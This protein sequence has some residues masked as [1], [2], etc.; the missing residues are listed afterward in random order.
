MQS[1]LLSGIFD[2]LVNLSF[3]TRC[4]QWI[5]DK[6]LW[7][8]QSLPLP[9]CLAPHLHSPAYTGPSVCSPHNLF[10]QPCTSPAAD[11]FQCFWLHRTIFQ[12]EWKSKQKTP[13]CMLNWLYLNVQKDW[14]LNSQWQEK[15]QKKRT[16]TFCFG[17]CF[18]SLEC[19]DKLQIILTGALWTIWHPCCE[20]GIY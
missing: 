20:S 5:K 13:I 9:H 1:G 3:T 7:Q 18:F 10:S 11:M 2:D 4:N 17:T 19:F 16:Q 8:S 12:M 14:S 15:I 6:N